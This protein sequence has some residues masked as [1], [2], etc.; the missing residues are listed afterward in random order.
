MKTK[1]RLRGQY[2]F[3]YYDPTTGRR[4]GS[5]V[6]D[7]SMCLAGL[8]YVMALLNLEGPTITPIYGAVGNG[9]SVT[10]GTADTRLAAEVGRVTLSYNARN[11][12]VNT[13]DFFFTTAQGNPGSGNLTEAGIF[14]VGSAT[15]N[16]G[17]LLSHVVI[18]EPKTVA[19]TMTMEFIMTLT[20][21]D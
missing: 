11:A 14:L 4:R 19:E 3:F 1:A 18:N 12:N 8:N 6:Y 9:A 21:G 2:K 20:S 16:S 15:V 10:P 5:V 7:N 13:W 17:Y